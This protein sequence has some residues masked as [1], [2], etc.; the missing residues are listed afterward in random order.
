MDRSE[1]KTHIRH[2]MQAARQALLEVLEHIDEDARVTPTENP[3]WRVGEI[4]AHLAASEKGMLRNV[5]RFLAGQELPEGF[6]LAYWN[7]RQ[8][9]KRAQTPLQDLVAEL[10]ASREQAWAILER[11][12]ESELDVAGTHP[13]GFRTTV[14]GLFYTIANHEL[15]H[16]NEIRRALGLETPLQPDW[17]LSK[18]EE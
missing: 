6:S 18:H 16:G 13:A 10:K 5:D 12:R 2:Y 1:R 11:L 17:S 3:Q 4:V 8:V 7:E 9:T 14:A 15:E